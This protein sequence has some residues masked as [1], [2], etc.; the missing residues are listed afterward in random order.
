NTTSSANGVKLAATGPRRSR[1]A[2]T[3]LI[4]A[5]TS[6]ECHGRIEPA[7]TLLVAVG[8]PDCAFAGLILIAVLEGGEAGGG[9]LPWPP[10]HAAPAGW[11]AAVVASAPHIAGP[12]FP[13]ALQPLA[14]HSPSAASSARR[15]VG[16]FQLT[17]YLPV[18]RSQAIAP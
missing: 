6:S 2:S 7:A 13:T 14:P 5:S 1:P 9:A 11:P 18:P 16:W 3:S 17:P 15:G 12:T 4:S 10:G 8:R